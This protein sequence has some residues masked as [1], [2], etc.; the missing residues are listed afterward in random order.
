[1]SRIVRVQGRTYDLG[2]KN[3]TFLTVARD[4]KI[5]GIKNWYFMLEICDISLINIDP[6]AVDKEGNCTLSNDQISRINLE[7]AR[8]PWYFLREVIHIPDAGGVGV[9]Y[10]A[11]R[12]NIAQAWCILHG[13]DSWLCLPRQRGKTISAIAIQVWAYIFGTTNSSFIQINKSGDDSKKNLSRMKNQL[14]LLPIYMQ[15]KYIYE[16]DKK[17]K[18]TENATR[19]ANPVTNNEVTTRS[20]ATSQEV[21]TNLAR[22]L[23][24]PILHFDEA[25][26]T[27]WIGIIVANSYQTYERAAE[28]AERNGAMHARIFTS[29]P[30]DLDT[31]A[32]MQSQQ[33]LDNTV[34]WT[35]R[36]YDWSMKKIHAYIDAQGIECNKILYIE[37]S[38]A[39]LGYSEEW[40][41]KIAAGTGNRLVFRRETLLQRLH[42]SS[43][44]PFDQEDLQY[45]VETEA[46]PIEEMWIL[47][48]YRFDI[49]E[50]LIKDIPYIA[51]ID[52]ST[53]TNKDNNAITII[54]PYTL[55]PVAEFECSFVGETMYERILI[56]LCRRL[57]YI[58]LCIERNS[59]GD[60]IIDHLLHSEYAGR[61]Y[62]DKAAK[63]QEAEMNRNSTWES[64]L[65]KRAAKKSYYGVY[66]GTDS[67]KTMM[68]ILA[69]RVSTKKDDFV[70]HNIIRDLTRL[71]MK[72]GGKIE[73]GSGEDDDG[74]GFH[75]DS[76]M[77][78]LIA[79]YVYFHG[80]NL[81]TFG[82]TRGLTEPE[83]LNKGL[84]RPEA[85]D[86][87]L[88]DKKL[89][90]G[91]KKQ[92]AKEAAFEK[93]S[94]YDRMMSEAIKQAQTESF[95]RYKSGLVQ[96]TV[97]ESTPEASLEQY[98]AFSDIPLNFFSDINKGT[99]P[100]QFQDDKFKVDDDNGLW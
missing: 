91:A 90:E 39:Q 56:E 42:G 72:P 50:K 36:M 65:K 10:L 22:G 28:T 6:Y 79:M 48:Y 73:A 64:M 57:P 9:N 35:E 18:A 55:R 69:D 49:Y 17:I 99:N 38:Y 34:K 26:F 60:G 12:G 67:R 33:I 29:T 63:L 68:S 11:N 3:K 82:I 45:I 92:L 75:D 25:E 84:K 43:E 62:F 80:D 4:L 78:Y 59:I 37:Y 93:E 44:S 24:A 23:T 52:C 86:S 77:S 8:N 41:D 14:D 71:V 87:E 94:N 7:C 19:L 20:K 58:V 5:L 70:T 74:N 2:T 54:N 32:G 46:V 83:E 1:M 89:I 13:L 81:A 85:I 66:T 53:G 98:D 16:E 40:L 21:A 100:N 95:R 31:R 97:Y 47:D 15:C 61:L 30:G 96:N 88:V 27:D 51:G 76:I